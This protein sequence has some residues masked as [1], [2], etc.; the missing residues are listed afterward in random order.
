MGDRCA[1]CEWCLSTIVILLHVFIRWCSSDVMRGVPEYWTKSTEQQEIVLSQNRWPS[2][3]RF[4]VLMG[5][6]DAAWSR[7]GMNL[8]RTHSRHFFRCRRHL[9][10]QRKRIYFQRR[11]IKIDTRNLWSKY[12]YVLY[13]ISLHVSWLNR[14]SERQQE[15]KESRNPLSSTS[16]AL[17]QTL[18]CKANLRLKGN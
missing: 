13:I 6:C 7:Y 8:V 14:W 10:S 3:K 11:E 18:S 9:L 16:T 1:E 17:E 12:M 5:W 15:G 4:W 2:V